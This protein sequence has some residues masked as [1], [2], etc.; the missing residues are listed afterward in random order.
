MKDEEGKLKPLLKAYSTAQGKTDEDQSEYE[1]KHGFVSRMELNSH[2]LDL[3]DD[4]TDEDYH[5]LYHLLW[6]LSTYRMLERH[7]KQRKEQ[8]D[9]I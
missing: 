1:A 6:T 4:L 7:K 9:T 5:S 2:I 3:M 8:G